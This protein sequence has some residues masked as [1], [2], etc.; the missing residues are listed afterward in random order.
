MEHSGGTKR[1]SSPLLRLLPRVGEESREAS[2]EASPE[3]SPAVATEVASP[4]VATEVASPGV[5]TEEAS[6]VAGAAE[7][8]AGAGGEDAPVG[9]FSPRRAAGGA[10]KFPSSSASAMCPIVGGSM[11]RLFG[12][13]LVR[14]APRSRSRAESC[15]LPAVVR[16]SSSRARSPCTSCDAHAIRAGKARERMH[17]HVHTA[18]CVCIHATYLRPPLGR[19]PPL[20][21]DTLVAA[22]RRHAEQPR[23]RQLRGAR[24]R[25]V[26]REQGGPCRERTRAQRRRLGGALAPR[27]QL[28]RL[29]QPPRVREHPARAARHRLLHRA[30]TPAPR[31]LLEPCG[32]F[33]L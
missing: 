24:Q 15:P 14:L 21:H 17:V 28:R 25:A 2:P 9:S 33:R 20:T 1:P 26:G 27:F 16:L 4:A 11:L 5:A 3:P 12:S 18:Q 22:L 19:A 23:R 10:S 31:L 29:A 30:T 8:A 6:P 7:E 32:P 13:S